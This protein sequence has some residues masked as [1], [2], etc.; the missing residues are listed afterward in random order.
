MRLDYNLFFS[1]IYSANNF[2]PLMKE[3]LRFSVIY[4][5]LS[6]NHGSI[7]DMTELYNNEMLNFGIDK[8]VKQKVMEIALNNFIKI[9]SAKIK[10]YKPD[11]NEINNRYSD[12]RV[13]QKGNRKY[14]IKN[15]PTQGKNVVIDGRISFIKFIK[16]PEL[17]LSD[18]EIK[19]IDQISLIFSRFAGLEGFEWIDDM[20]N[21][22][23]DLMGLDLK[24]S[25]KISYE[26]RLAPG[27]KK[28]YDIIRDALF[29][30]NLI[31]IKRINNNNAITTLDFSP[32]FLKLF[33]NKWYVFGHV[34]NQVYPYV[35][36]VDKS[37]RNVETS[38]YKYVDSEI[39]FRDKIDFNSDINFFDKFIGVTNKGS[40][41]KI[42]FKVHDEKSFL[43][44]DKKPPHYS[45]EQIKDYRGYMF[46]LQVKLNPELN[47][48]ILENI[49]CLEVL[50]PQKL[51]DSIRDI[52]NKSSAKY[53]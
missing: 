38:K 29:D 27:S 34:A 22:S 30:E 41:E 37:I 18:D 3:A 33:K 17:I 6:N 46:S 19:H 16:V 20:K 10:Y 23:T 44:I 21:S 51:R 14:R 36:P 53:R 8:S 32:H 49:D 35:V 4:K 42:I 26:E 45:Y 25:N 9:Y 47:R 43:R 1:H 13:I 24:S 15:Y 52:L 31:K 48:F 40:Y 2:Y 7:H 50:S 5:S 28:H 12:L 11:E 39:D